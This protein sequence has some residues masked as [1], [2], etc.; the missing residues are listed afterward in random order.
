MPRDNSWV[1]S[2]KC[3]D[4]IKWYKNHI[5]LSFAGMLDNPGCFLMIFRPLLWISFQKTPWSIKFIWDDKILNFWTVLTVRNHLYKIVFNI[6]YIFQ[7]L[8]DIFHYVFNFRVPWLTSKVKIKFCRLY[9]QIL[10]TGSYLSNMFICLKGKF[11]PGIF[12]LDIV[13]FISFLMLV[14]LIC[15][16]FLNI[17]FITYLSVYYIVNEDSDLQ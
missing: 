14:S 1:E 7:C 15:L 10:N 3:I 11:N 8:V 17:Y 9:K 13:I 16:W 4:E 12:F 2:N 5:R 6:W